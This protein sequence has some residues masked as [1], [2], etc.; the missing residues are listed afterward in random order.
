ME[1]IF[2]K[3]ITGRWEGRR[4]VKEEKERS[5]N[6]NSG[7]NFPK[8]HLYRTIV[9]FVHKQKVKETGF[10]NSVSQPSMAMLKKY[11]RNRT[12]SAG[13][14]E[15]TKQQQKTTL[16]RLKGADEQLGMI[17]AEGKEGSY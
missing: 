6:R 12:T 7:L 17:E 5:V 4:G 10:E 1:D 13:L 3:G 2:Q 8:R 16:R 14:K 9:G 15:T 11:F